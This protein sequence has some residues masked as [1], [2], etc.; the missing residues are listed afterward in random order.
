[1][2]KDPLGGGV[3]VFHADLRAQSEAEHNVRAGLNQPGVACLALGAELLNIARG[4]LCVRV[5]RD[6]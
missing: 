5:L 3:D 2:P 1:M 4:R 6:I